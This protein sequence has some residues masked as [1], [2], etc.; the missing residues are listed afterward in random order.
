MQ[1]ALTEFT[2]WTEMYCATNSDKLVK[3]NAI[4][5]SKPQKNT[6]NGKRITSKINVH[7]RSKRSGTL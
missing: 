7:T 1:Y 3:I 6:V 5:Q 4:I 2:Q